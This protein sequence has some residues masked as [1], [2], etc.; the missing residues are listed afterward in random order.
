MRHNTIPFPFPRIPVTLGW[1]WSTV[2]KEVPADAGLEW[3]GLAHE[4]LGALVITLANFI[5]DPEASWDWNL[6]VFLLGALGH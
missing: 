4:N 6:D 5:S 1:E 2:S 3:S